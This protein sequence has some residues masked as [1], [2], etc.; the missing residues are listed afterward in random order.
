MSEYFFHSLESSPLYFLQCL[1]C[2]ARLLFN[3]FLQDH[4][5]LLY[6]DQAVIGLVLSVETDHATDVV[7]FVAEVVTQAF[8]R[9]RLRDIIWNAHRIH[10]SVVL[11]RILRL[12]EVIV[13]FFGEG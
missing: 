7:Q 11:D 2:S 9:C 6:F 4:F 1:G 8:G 12:P 10:V 13:I 5:F 3:L